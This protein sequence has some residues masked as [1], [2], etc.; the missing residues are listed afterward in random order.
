M[1]KKNK[2]KKQKGDTQTFC[3]L[4]NDHKKNINVLKD[5]VSKS[6]IELTQYSVENTTGCPFDGI[7]PI[8]ATDAVKTKV[9]PLEFNGYYSNSVF[10][11]FEMSLSIPVRQTLVITINAEDVPYAFKTGSNESITNLL[12]RTNL[13]LVLNDINKP[14]K[15][16]NKWVES[17]A[18]EDMD[19]FVINIPELVMF[20][21][22]IRKD[23]ISEGLFFN[24][25]IQVIKSN[26][27]IEK[28]KKKGQIE[29]LSKFIIK[30]TLENIKSFGNTSVVIEL[31]DDFSEDWQELA[32][33]WRI[34]IQ[35][36]EGI[37]KIVNRISFT[38]TNGTGFAIMT[39]ELWNALSNTKSVSSK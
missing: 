32:E 18:E 25:T 14:M 2:N 21:N 24:L 1:A 31:T 3:N 37:S 6:L 8:S 33:N 30:C 19:M 35:N 7:V 5:E 4:L 28:L 23:K 16:L 11:L 26:K 15:K 36:D 9:A 10:K 34:M 12:E 22:K 17:E 39:N 27:S 29:T 20:T 13:S 38:I